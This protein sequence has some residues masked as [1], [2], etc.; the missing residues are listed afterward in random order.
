MCHDLRHKARASSKQKFHFELICL[1]IQKQIQ[2]VQM[3]NSQT[4]PLLDVLHS[5][6][7]AY[8]NIITDLVYRE[9]HLLFYN[10]LTAEGI[11]LS[12]SLQ[13]KC[14]GKTALNNI[15]VVK[16]HQRTLCNV[17]VVARCDRTTVN[18]QH[19]SS[20]QLYRAFL[21]LLAHCFGFTPHKCTILAHRVFI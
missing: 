8:N 20:P 16:M 13:P 11:C 21:H 19:F 9:I 2:S 4:G 1:F 6:C 15:F 12:L 5:R 7:H 10:C 18:Y 17:K 3:L 14:Y